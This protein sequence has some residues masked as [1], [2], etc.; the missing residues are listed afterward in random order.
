[1]IRAVR[2]R[3]INVA[4]GAFQLGVAVKDLKRRV[5]PLDPPKPKEVKKVVAKPK[6]N[7]LEKEIKFFS[8]EAMSDENIRLKNIQELVKKARCVRQSESILFSFF[9]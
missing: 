6:L 1:M 8:D 2:R 4:E 5:G 3:D 9:L 7:P